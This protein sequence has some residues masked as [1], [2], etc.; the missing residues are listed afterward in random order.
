MKVMILAAGLGTRLQPLTEQCPKPLLPVMGC[1]LLEHILRQLQLWPV[2]EVVINVHHHAEQLQRWLGTGLGWGFPIHL[3]YEAEI[4]GTAGAL[5]H[6]ALWL[7]DE[8][9][10]V[11]NAD[12]LA[13]FNLAAIWQA[14]C[15]GDAMVT[16]VL[17]DDPAARQFGAVMVDADN[18]IYQISGRPEIVTSLDCEAAMFA[19]A[20]VVSPRVLDWIEPYQFVMTTSETYPALITAGE[21]VM[22]HRYS[23]YWIDVGIRERYLQAHWDFFDG[24]MGDAWK[25]YLPGGTQFIL[26]DRAAAASVAQLIPPVVIGPRVDLAPDAMVGP[27]VVLGSDC[28]I[29]SGAV[30]R[31]SVLWDGVQVGSE[32]EL[33]YSVIGADCRVDAAS[34]VTDTLYIGDI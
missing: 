20:Q 12:V 11:I 10:V 1:P 28:H 16:M 15:E 14:H 3:S 23:G 21:A 25:Q 19:C 33:I 17:R 27:Y 4:L 31:H 32:A 34:E 6:A 5:K 2:T 8:P 18:R 13:H 9:F 7:K 29:G 22:A 24:W 26:D 30:V